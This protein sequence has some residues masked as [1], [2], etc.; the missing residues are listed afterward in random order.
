MYAVLLATHNVVRWLVLAVGLYAVVR[1]WRG[2][3]TRAVWT[4]RDAR[5]LKTFP[6]TASLQ[7]VLGILLY[8]MS[9]LIRQGWGDFGAAMR[10]PALRKFVVEHPIMMIAFVALAHI[11]AGRVRKATSDSGRFQTAT[12][13]WGVALAIALGFIPWNSPLLPF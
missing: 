8:I 12:I 10:D 4:E 1:V 13:F 7:F 9:P 11:G 2:W 6:G 5:L 3:M